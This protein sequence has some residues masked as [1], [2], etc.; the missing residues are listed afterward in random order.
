MA[1]TFAAMTHL[2]EAVTG[3]GGVALRYGGLYGPHEDT[4]TK[5]VRKRRYP[6]IG[7]GGGITSFIDLHT[8]RQRP[9]SRSSMTARPSTTSPMTSPPRCASGCPRWRLRSAPSRPATTRSG[10]GG[11]SWAM[12]WP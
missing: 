6:V 8:P 9:C 10:Q 4:Q 7:D 1:R 2:D 11:C 5:A 3:A 12:P